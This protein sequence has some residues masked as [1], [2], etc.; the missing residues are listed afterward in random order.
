ML[1]K[2]KIIG[3]IKITTTTSFGKNN[4]LENVLFNFVKKIN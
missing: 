4:K 2:K 3:V 1:F